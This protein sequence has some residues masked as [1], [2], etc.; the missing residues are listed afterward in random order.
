MKK[1]TG[2]ILICIAIGLALVGCDESSDL[3]NPA[4]G[5]PGHQKLAAWSPEETATI[6]ESEG[7]VTATTSLVT[8]RSG[9][10]IRN[11]GTKQDPQPEHGFI[12]AWNPS[13]STN[14]CEEQFDHF[15]ASIYGPSYCHFKILDASG[16]CILF[17]SSLWGATDLGI[18]LL[19]LELPVGEALT[20]DNI[21][22]SSGSDFNHI[23]LYGY[24]QVAG[25]TLERGETYTIQITEQ[26]AGWNTSRDGELVRFEQQVTVPCC[27]GM[28]G[29]VDGDPADQI[30]ISDLVALVE[31]MFEGGSISCLAEADVNGS[32]QV[33]ISDLNYLT[34]YM[35]EGGP[36]PVACD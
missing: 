33:D 31:Y 32:G 11:Y 19:R 27:V 2:L 13:N 23:I 18:S 8:V 3:T 7:G 21:V 34:S 1:R 26:V 35:F 9:F 29:N 12:K 24:Y 25:F 22:H 4:T 28:R 16:D 15:D 20:F 6:G 10:T 14:A 17:N 36:A 30:D 5:D